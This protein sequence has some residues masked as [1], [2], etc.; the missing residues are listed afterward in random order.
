MP[1]CVFGFVG[2]DCLCYI[3]AGIGYLYIAY[4]G[5]ESGMEN[6][7]IN[8]HTQISSSTPFFLATVN[9]Q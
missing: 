5:V 1:D 9:E 8:L 6:K 7:V 4:N 3:N 2:S